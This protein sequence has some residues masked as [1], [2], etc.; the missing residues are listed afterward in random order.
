MRSSRWYALSAAH[1]RHVEADLRIRS[2][3]LGEAARGMSEPRS[4]DKLKAA[5]LD[6]ALKRAPD[7]GFSDAMLAAAGKDAGAAPEMMVHLFPQGPASL[8]EFFSEQSDAAMERALAEKKLGQM[9]VRERISTA[10]LTRIDL[11]R[12]N[13][14]AARRAA[15]FLL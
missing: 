7:E 12:S 9:K 14:E 1:A 5:V 8:V 10:V 2:A 6:A 4:S 3:S 11:L 15:P 13:K